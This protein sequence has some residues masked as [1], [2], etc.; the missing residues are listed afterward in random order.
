MAKIEN[1]RCQRILDSRGD[2]TIETKIS[3]DDG[4]VV[5]QPVPSGTSVGENEAKYIDEEKAADFV[6]TSINDI[7][8]GKD[9]ANQ[10][11]IDEILIKMDG[12][13]DK[14][15]LGANSMVSVS[16]ATA[17]A[18][19]KSKD[20]EL[21]SYLSI[22]YNGKEK[23]KG[24]LT[25]PT[26]IFNVLNG[27]KHARNNLSF[28]EF[29]VIPALNTPLNKAIDMGAEIYKDLRQLLTREEF[30]T[31][32][33]DEGGF[34]PE[35]LSADTALDFLK[36]AID[37][38]Y[39]VGSDVF[40][41]MDAAAGSF[42]KNGKYLIKEEHLNL[43]SEEMIA[44]YS[45]IFSKYELIY[46]EDPLFEKDL[47]GWKELHRKFANKLMVVGDD[48]V[49]TN[50]EILKTVI[51][52]K[53]INAVIVKPNQVG[54]LTETFAFIKE[55]KNSKMSVIISHRS[56]DNPNDTFISDLAVAVGADFIKSGAP[57]RGERVAKYNRLL[58]IFYGF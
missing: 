14:S 30:E 42:Y 6:S 31:G 37:S 7:L 35:G 39:E 38:H 16:L 45:N 28:Q 54:T 4:T 1:V 17:Q 29:M 44:Y 26:P 18:A 56:G 20:L 47:L 9:P 41:G 48:L 46:L 51:K 33:G 36:R 43:T 23:P 5:V 22:L 53:M 34:E 8:I 52:E 25:F 15:R 13:K 49:V 21:Y 40:F 19:A 32:V 3:L 50:P 24:E 55:A 27:G 11:F 2:W 57:A 12:T 10:K 58:E